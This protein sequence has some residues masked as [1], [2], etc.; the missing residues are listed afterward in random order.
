MPGNSLV[1][2]AARHCHAGAAGSSQPLEGNKSHSHSCVLLA[3]FMRVFLHGLITAVSQ[4][5]Q[6]VFKPETPPPKFS[7]CTWFGEGRAGFL[8]MR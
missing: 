1:C 5:D 6:G 3:P 4:H 2:R 8:G 7:S